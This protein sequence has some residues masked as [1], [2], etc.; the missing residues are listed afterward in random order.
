MKKTIK[1]KISKSRK[2][3]RIKKESKIKGVLKSIKKRGTTS[4]EEKVKDLLTSMNLNFIK[5]APIKL[6]G[7]TKFYDFYVF[8]E[9]EYEFFIECHGNY[10]HPMIFKEDEEILSIPKEKLTGIQKRNIKNDRFKIRLSKRIK[11]PLLIFY[12][13]DINKNIDKLKNI[14]LEQIKK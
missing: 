13:T 8:K 7:V 11:I 12:E 9:N 6:G 2:T 4:I 10:W 1:Q 14:I 5:E 3:K